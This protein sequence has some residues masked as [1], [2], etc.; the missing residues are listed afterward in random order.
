MVSDYLIY[1]DGVLIVSVAGGE[2]THTVKELVPGL[3]WS[4]VNATG[5]V[6]RYVG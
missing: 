2:T 1:Q 5:L 3:Y 4:S 6:E